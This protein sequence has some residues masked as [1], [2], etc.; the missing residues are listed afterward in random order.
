[1]KTKN[2]TLVLLE[3]VIVLCSVFLVTTLPAIAAEQNQAI[4]KVSE[5]EVMSASKDDFVLGVYG[6][7]NEDDTIDIRDPS[8]VKLISFGKKPE[9]KLADAKYDGKPEDGIG[10]TSYV[11]PDG[12]DEDYH[13]LMTKFENYLGAAAPAPTPAGPPKS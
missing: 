9:T 7:A 4:Q 13:P 12:I 2:K 8:Y 6:N 3:I 10:D 11:V 1:M 5:S